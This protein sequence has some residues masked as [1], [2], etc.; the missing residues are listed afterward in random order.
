[1]SW[2]MELEQISQSWNM[3]NS[4]DQVLRNPYWHEFQVMK[5]GLYL[6]HL[7][8]SRPCLRTV[9]NFINEL[10]KKSTEMNYTGNPSR[11]LSSITSKFIHEGGIYYPYLNWSEGDNIPNTKITN[12]LITSV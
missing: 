1:M 10:T 12:L 3:D 6:T 8:N 2:I 9:L 7:M 4:G 11:G 5:Y